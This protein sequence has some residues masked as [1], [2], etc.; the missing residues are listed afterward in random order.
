MELRVDDHEVRARLAKV[1]E[2]GADGRV[3]L[4]AFYQ[5][6]KA[7]MAADWGGIRAAGGGSMRG[8]SWAPMAPQYTRKD[9][10]VVP[11]WG[12]VPRVREGFRKRVKG[13]ERGKSTGERMSNVSGTVSGRR[14]PSGKRVTQT[15]VINMDTG[16]LKSEIL[17]SRPN[18]INRT[19]LRIGGNFNRA[20]AY[21]EHVLE[22]LHRNPLFWALPRDE[23]RLSARVR[24]WLDK[25]ATDFNRGR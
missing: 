16:T 13:P 6:V 24:Q 4:T 2:A 7:D 19:R 18:I 17:T 11:A 9:G 8:H 10:T 1:I 21:A 12:G 25:I 22:D 20:S 23:Q 14:R 3:P 15:S 5:E